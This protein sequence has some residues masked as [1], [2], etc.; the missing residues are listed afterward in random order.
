[1]SNLNTAPPGALELLEKVKTL[2]GAGSG[3]DADLSR[4]LTVKRLVFNHLTTTILY[5]DGIASVTD[6]GKGLMVVNFSTP[7]ANANWI[8]K[9]TV[10]LECGYD[11]GSVGL[12]QHVTKEA[13]RA[14]VKISN[15][16]GKQFDSSCVMLEFIGA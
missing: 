15:S 11:I 10:K 6:S 14:S 3:L 7:F 2:D 4:G 12:K 9:G 5:S 16:Y 1:M 8:M 13:G